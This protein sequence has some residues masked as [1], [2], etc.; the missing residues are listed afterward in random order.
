MVIRYKKPSPFLAQFVSHFWEK[1]NPPDQKIG[2]DTETVLPE[3][4]LNL[5]FSLGTPYYRFSDKE[6]V[7]EKLH[8]P[9]LAAMHTTQNFYKHQLDNHIFGV[10]FLPGG[11]YPFVSNDFLGITDVTLDMELIFG[12][13]VNFLADELFHL[14]DFTSRVARIEL[15]L[16]QRLLER[17]LQKFN[18]VRLA[19]SYIST[20]NAHADIAKVAEELNSNY[21]TLSRAFYEVIGVAPKQFAQM[22]RFERALNLLF[23]EMQLNCTEIGYKSGYYDQA[24]F[25]R[26]FKKFAGQ[27]P[28]EY[29]ERIRPAAPS[30]ER[31]DF[32]QFFSPEHLLFYYLE[33]C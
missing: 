30:T 3:P 5:T 9:Q 23:S 15:F 27:T 13:E 20:Q 31:I 29:L 25:I 14:P 2:Y 18:F 12:K 21:K 17:K 28:T 6:A 19:T 22:L 1:N 26:E 32:Q 16:M 4:Y 7:F 33:V 8:T 11:L 24:H 10:K